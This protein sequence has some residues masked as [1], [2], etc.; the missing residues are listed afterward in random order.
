MAS[1]T[2]GVFELVAGTALA[3]GDVLPY[4]DISVN[5]QAGQGS[6]LKIT[7]ANF[8]TNVPVAVTL[9][10]TLAVMG[11]AGFGGVA[12]SAAAVLTTSS[13]TLAGANQQGIINRPVFTSS[14]TGTGRSLDVQLVTAAA[15]FT[16]TAGAGLHVNTPSLGAASAITT[17]YGMFV[18]TQ[19]GGGTNYGIYVTGADAGKGIYVAGGGLT[20]ASGST[21]VQAFSA[22]TGTFSDNVSVV[23]TKKVALNAGLTS[24]IYEGSAG[25]VTVNA[26]SGIVL[27]VGSFVGFNITDRIA[28][29][30]MSTTNSSAGNL[31]ITSSS[32]PSGN[33]TGGGFLWVEAGALKYRGTSGTVTTLGPA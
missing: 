17:V 1:T 25:V 33:P 12:S 10:S 18:D 8:F 26:A 29:G 21:A 28:I 14:A 3:S 23:A 5:T 22:T 4:V 9:S 32:A 24:Y 19:S 20:V 7:V 11:N 27:N 2:S 13:T 31:A 16:M 6:L 15:A 30:T